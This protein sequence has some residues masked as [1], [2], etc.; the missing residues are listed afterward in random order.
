MASKKQVEQAAPIKQFSEAVHAFEARGDLNA[1]TKAFANLLNIIF[2]NGKH[3]GWHN[4]L[5]PTKRRDFQNILDNVRAAQKMLDAALK[6]TP[7]PD[8]FKVALPHFVQM[9]EKLNVVFSATDEQK[10]LPHGPWKISNISGLDEERLKGFLALVDKADSIL[11][12]RF[13]K[14]LHGS[15]HLGNTVSAGHAL[16]SYS[17]GQDAIQ[18]S[19][20]ELHKVYE[21]TWNKRVLD[22]VLKSF[23]HE[24]GHR[25]WY[26][27]SNKAERDEFRKLSTEPEFFQFEV[28][29]DAKMRERMAEEYLTIAKARVKRKKIVPSPELVGW[30]R[31]MHARGDFLPLDKLTERI[32]E[33]PAVETEILKA[34]RGTKNETLVIEGEKLHDGIAVSEYGATK[35]EENFAEGFAYY[36]LG[37]DMHPEMVAFFKAL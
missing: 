10:V 32:K 14:V 11:R 8:R 3:P 17:P 37:K 2:P 15:I 21:G 34:V 28:N 1:L 26:K 22:D 27:F 29:Y 12:G 19:V 4:T 31:A 20:K 16:A 36:A 23:I 24:L 33:G 6:G 30:L 13:E 18:I 5:A 35:V 9:L 25:Y 7:L